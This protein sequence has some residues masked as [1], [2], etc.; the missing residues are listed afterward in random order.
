MKEIFTKNPLFFSFLFPALV[1]AIWTIAGQDSS[2]WQNPQNVR[3]AGPL[4]YIL[5]VS[6]VVYI[7]LA[8]VWFVF[9]YWIFTKLKSPYN[10]IIAIAFI[11]GHTWGTSTWIVN[12]LNTTALL[13]SFSYRNLL[14]F[15]WIVMAV[16]CVIIA[17]LAGL[18]IDYYKKNKQ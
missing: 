17:I 11:S 15:E 1:D 10:L 4:Y 13:A 2:Y 18:S 16:Y 9:L 7:I 5:M 6:P 12:Y 3:E 14:L 8:I